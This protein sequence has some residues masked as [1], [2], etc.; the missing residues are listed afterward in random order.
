M[1]VLE[2]LSQTP[3]DSSTSRR[4]TEVEMRNGLTPKLVTWRQST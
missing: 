4:A 1:Y 3:G 2:V